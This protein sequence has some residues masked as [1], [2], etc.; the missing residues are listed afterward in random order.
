VLTVECWPC[1]VLVLVSGPSGPCEVVPG[2]KWS[3]TFF[4]FFF[5]FFFESDWSVLYHV[6]VNIFC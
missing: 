1:G 4:F 2:L 3:V 5:F 6:F